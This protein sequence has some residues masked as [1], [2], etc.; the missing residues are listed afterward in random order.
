MLA[1]W[2]R[3]PGLTGGA[4]ATGNTATIL[5]RKVVRTYDA[6]NRISTLEFPDN[7]GNQAWDYTP[8]GLPESITTYNDG[9]ASSVVN[10]YLYNK[11]RLPV[12]ET[13]QADTY[14]WTVGYGY[15]GNGHLASLTY[16]DSL[17]V[18]YAQASRLIYG[19]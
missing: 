11:R 2:R 9:G 5:A 14:T 17:A 3:H 4:F 6:R 10:S 1:D 13:L 12:S 15:T 16:P 8:D 7:N 19:I 18:D